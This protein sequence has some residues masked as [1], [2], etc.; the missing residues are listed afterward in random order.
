MNSWLELPSKVRW[1]IFRQFQSLEQ[2]LTDTACQAVGF[3]AEDLQF[4]W[5]PVHTGCD[6]HAEKMLLRGH[7]QGQRSKVQ[8]E[9]VALLP[10]QRPGATRQARATACISSQPGCGVGCPFCATGRLGYQGDL[11]ASEIAE[12][13]YWVGRQAAL[14]GRPLRNVVYMGMG[15]P[16]HNTQQVIQSLEWLTH[17]ALFGLPQRRIMVSTVG[18]PSAM[19]QLSQ[20]FPMIKWALSLH[21]AD[22]QQR[23]A[24][25]PKAAADLQVLRTTIRQLN[26]LQRDGVWLEVVLL[27][28]VND[29]L[30]H[31]QLL[32]DFC[33]GLRVE[34]NLIPY[35][36]TRLLPNSTRSTSNVQSFGDV[37]SSSNVPGFKA[38]TRADREAF[39]HKLRSQG[40]RTTIRTSFGSES[41]AACGQ[42]QASMVI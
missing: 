24:L 25:V 31:A 19:L 17:P 23:R 22:P 16:L 13:V 33:R 18:V 28:G 27:G 10:P 21:S 9:T 34:V 30:A 39:A 4:N 3:R 36:N 6:P 15:E 42:L 40:I 7:P 20:R 41:S 2:L 32:V 8:C 1:K 38:S 29:S 14:R 11:T 5:F 35:N 12:Q 26:Q 37:Q